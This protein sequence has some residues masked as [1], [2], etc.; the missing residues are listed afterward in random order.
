MG[1]SSPQASAMSKSS[2][3]TQKQMSPL[4]KMPP[5]LRRNLFT[6]L[7]KADIVRQAP[8]RYLIRPYY[9]HNAVLSV[10]NKMQNEAH[11][12]LY[13]EN[14]LVTISSDRE[15]IVTCITNHKVTTVYQKP[16]L[17]TRFKNNIIRLHIKFPWVNTQGNTKVLAS[18]IILAQDL[19][20]FTR[21][22]HILDVTN[23][24]TRRQRNFNF[25]IKST[26]ACPPS[27]AIRKTL[28]KVRHF[29]V[30][31]S[32]RHFSLTSASCFTTFI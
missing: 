2:A 20:I 25:L 14:H 21:L 19:P 1:V 26:D 4:E 17:R 28:L 23:S 18:F 27:L 24:G 30:P 8:D 16:Q 10:S 31:P 3:A 29:R 9:F 6:N 13:R 12:V 32:F 5:E 7:L 11:E 15:T 22:L